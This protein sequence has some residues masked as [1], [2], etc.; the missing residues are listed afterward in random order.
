MTVAMPRPTQVQP[1]R[2][3]KPTTSRLFVRLITV[4]LV[5]AVSALV[6]LSTPLAGLAG[7]ALVAV[8]LQVAVSVARSARHGS[9]A[10]RNDVATS[11]IGSAFLLLMT[12]W[13]SVLYTVV[14]RGYEAI[15]WNFLTD[16]MRVTA[17]DAELGLGGI[18]HAIVGTGVMVLIATAVSVPLGILSGIYVTEIRGRFTKLVRF[19][20]QAMSG[21]PSIVAGLFIYSTL[22]IYNKSYSGFAGALALAVLMIP[23]V[24]R[25]AE[26]VLKLVPEELRFAGYALGSTQAS[27]VFRVVL[28]T[29][30][31][32]LV[33][34]AILGV[35]RVA[36]ETAPLLMT[37]Q[38]FLATK[39]NPFDGPLGSLPVVIFSFFQNGADNAV[40]R[41]WGASTVLMVLIMFLF[42]LARAV[43]AD[44]RRSRR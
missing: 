36:G 40:T 5:V 18:A 22:V 30:R 41:A 11:L 8:P 44:R 6:V 33:T 29:V 32:G 37:A 3:W 12:P 43:S 15:S 28:P 13:L 35:A 34:S 39:G 9:V 17:P 27:N 16:D 25:T 21:V 7:V 31:S 10:A 19:I 20:V 24:A 1:V 2:P 23:T 38:V 4:L 14:R 26:E 42:A